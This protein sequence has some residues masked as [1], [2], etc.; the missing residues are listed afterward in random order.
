MSSN[1]DGYASGSSTSTSNSDLSSS[2]MSSIST[3][4]KKRKRTKKK[5]KDQ[6]RKEKRKLR[7]SLTK[8]SY[9]GSTAKRSYKLFEGCSFPKSPVGPQALKAF[10]IRFCHGLKATGCAYYIDKDPAL[11]V[12]IPSKSSSLKKW[13]RYVKG[14]RLISMALLHVL[15]GHPEAYVL[16]KD[17]ADGVK[18]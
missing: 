3:Y 16:I 17:E 2:S 18:A 8:H 5:T 11:R 10:M 9:G 15:M 12:K 13:K 1:P 14:V 4:K 7:K 6:I